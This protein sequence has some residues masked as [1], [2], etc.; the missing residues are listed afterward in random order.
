[1]EAQR[2]DLGGWPAGSSAEAAGPGP[3]PGV[4]GLVLLPGRGVSSPEG[5]ASG[6]LCGPWCSVPLG[7]GSG[8]LVHR[9]DTQRP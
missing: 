7:T 2:W 4:P 1:M 5:A 9:V 6:R 3:R 8:W